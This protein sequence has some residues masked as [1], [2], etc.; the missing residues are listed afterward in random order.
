MKVHIVERT[1]QN[2]VHSE[3]T[4]WSNRS[5]GRGRNFRVVLH[6]VARHLHECLLE[7]GAFLDQLVDGEAVSSGQVT[8]VIGRHPPH[9]QRPVDRFGGHVLGAQQLDEL[10]GLR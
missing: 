7:R 10:R 8:D 6:A 2:F 9:P 3:R 4:T 1:D 5:V